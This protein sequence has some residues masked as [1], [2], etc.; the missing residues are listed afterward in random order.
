[1]SFFFFFFFF[2]VCFY[3]IPFRD[4]SFP[5]Q[6]HLSLQSLFAISHPNLSLRSL[7][8][9]LSLCAGT[10]GWLRKASTTCPSP[11]DIIRETARS[12]DSPT[13]LRGTGRK[14][15][16]IEHHHINLFAD[17]YGIDLF[18]ECYCID[19]FVESMR[20]MGSYHFIWLSSVTNQINSS[21]WLTFSLSLHLSLSISLSLSQDWWCDVG[22]PGS[23]DGAASTRG[24][25][26]GGERS[27]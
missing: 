1:M 27:R 13:P 17:Y 21:P 8:L 23:A 10:R 6:H 25:R 12:A 7:S 15:L 3:F 19:L 18:V 9:S 14:N 4:G 24:K 22:P 11:R 5:Y 26:K 2:L 16:F 20:S